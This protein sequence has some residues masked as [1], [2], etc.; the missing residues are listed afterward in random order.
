MGGSNQGT[1]SPPPVST[2]KPAQ[3][4]AQ[5]ATRADITNFNPIRYH[6]SQPD[7]EVH[8]HDDSTKLKCAID[9]ASFFEAYHGWRAVMGNNLVL[10]GHDGKK[11][12]SRVE[13]MPWV[14]DNGDMQVAITVD[15]ATLGNTLQDL[16]KMASYP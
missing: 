7:G 16:D 5:R 9:S 3:K 10:A 4:K 2:T 12:H 15:P 6:E 14:D 11:G 13:F 8:F 1:C